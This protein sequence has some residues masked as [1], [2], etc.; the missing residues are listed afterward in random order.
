[1]TI[2]NA[3]IKLYICGDGD[4]REEII[5]LSRVD[6]RINYLGLVKREHALLY[7]KNA[8]LLVNPRT[9]EGA[10]TKYSFPS[11]IMEYL[12][13]GVP[14]LMYR[15]PGIPTEYYDYCYAV[16]E[17]GIEYLSDALEKVINISEEQ[18]RSKGDLARKFILS[19]KCPKVQTKKIV[20]LISSL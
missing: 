17:T 19:K 1:M 9:P 10:F 12:A 4:A 18:R 8:M 16:E 6:G 3:D 15:L 11:K 5:K 7:Q 2:K 13:S 20:D 14:T